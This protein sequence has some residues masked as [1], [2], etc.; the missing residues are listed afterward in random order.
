MRRVIRCIVVTGLIIVAVG[1]LV[2]FAAYT[3]LAF[4]Q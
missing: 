4:T 2:L 3:G 1:E